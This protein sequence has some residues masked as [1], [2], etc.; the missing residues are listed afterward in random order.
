MVENKR[1]KELKKILK[2]YVNDQASST[3]VDAVNHWYDT[4][5]VS[6]PNTRDI[7]QSRKP[8]VIPLHIWAPAVCICMMTV[9]AGWF[10]FSADPVQTTERLIRTSAAERKE[11]TLTDGTVVVLNTGTELLVSG[12][13]NNEERRVVLKGEA[14]FRVAKNPRKPFFIQSGQLCTQVLGTSFNI[15]AYPSRER[16]K[17]SVLTG[18]VRVTQTK[19]KAE[20]VLADH[21]VANQTISFFKKTGKF[22]RNTEDA[23]L[24]TSW[25]DNKLYIDNASIPDIAE[26]L[27]G[28]YNLDVKDLSYANSE[29]RYTIRFNKESM[30]SVLEIL[31]QL[32]KRE[33]G[34]SNKQITI[35]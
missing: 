22:E 2:R 15:S 32:T 30:K 17:V 27:K 35:K 31:T 7:S 28:F 20:M 8:K 9:F 24:I 25:K 26:Q 33:F 14:Y 29:D 18:L 34:Y 3:E 12:N 4:L 5:E 10:Y 6:N 1:E 11:V 23:M 16:I 13:Y 21:M 19:D